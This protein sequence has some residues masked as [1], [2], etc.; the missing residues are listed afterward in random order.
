M[1]NASERGNTDCENLQ[2]PSHD[3]KFGKEVDLLEGRGRKKLPRPVEH[4]F[5]GAFL[6]AALVGVMLTFGGVKILMGLYGNDALRSWGAS[7]LGL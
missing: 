6:I 5:F 7:K 4:V 3:K 1:N 2:V